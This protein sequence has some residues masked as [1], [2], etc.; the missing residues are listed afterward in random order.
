MQLRV[1]I[2]LISMACFT[3]VLHAAQGN[4]ETVLNRSIQA[5]SEQSF[6]DR[7]Q[8]TPETAQQLARIQAQQK[9]LASQVE[10]ARLQQELI[11]LQQPTAP[12][13]PQGQTA[14]VISNPLPQ[15]SA[16]HKWWTVAQR[17][18]YVA[19]PLVAATIV[20]GWYRYRLYTR[21]ADELAEAENLLEEQQFSQPPIPP[22]AAA[23]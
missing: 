4:Q 5:L 18:T 19:Y 10:I 17:Y 8:L 6:F 2:V 14:V 1:T 11:R 23:E 21:T 3:A 16:S 20:Y 13:I 22:T 9:I 12:I 7:T 15:T